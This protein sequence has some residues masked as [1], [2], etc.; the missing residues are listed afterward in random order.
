M[1]ITSR[2]LIRGTALPIALAAACGAAALLPAAGD[3]AGGKTQTLRFFD[4]VVSTTLTAPDGTVVHRE[5]AAGDTL[6]VVSLEYPGNH[7]KHAKKATG[8]NHLR[9]VFPATPGPPDCIS[10]VA[11]GGS[12]LVFEGFP[13][14]LVL[15]TGTYLGATGRVIR[16]TDVGNNNSD[17]VARITLR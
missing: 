5:P 11:F 9:C 3:A 2:H 10:H 7:V 15:G 6:D 12:M 8:T 14:T 13:G 1:S 16:N 4:K 17:V